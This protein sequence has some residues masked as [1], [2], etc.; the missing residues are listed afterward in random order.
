MVTGASHC[1]ELIGREACGNAAIL[2]AN[3]R[4]NADTMDRYPFR[5]QE[6]E[7]P[8]AV[9]AFKAVVPRWGGREANAQTIKINRAAADTR[10]AVCNDTVKFSSPAAGARCGATAVRLGREKVCDAYSQE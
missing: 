1:S 7:L 6:Y 8:L 5:N 9:R 3:N 4:S 10:S 2:A